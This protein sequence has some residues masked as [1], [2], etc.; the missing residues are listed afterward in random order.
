MGKKKASPGSTAKHVAVESLHTMK[1]G[2]TAIANVEGHAA[3][4]DSKEFVAARSALHEIIKELGDNFFGDGPVQAHHGGSI[5]VHDGKSWRM[6]VNL[7]GIEWS[8]QFAC[9]P[10]KVDKLRVNAK[11]LVDA[12]PQTIPNLTRIGYH[13]AERILGTPIVDGDTIG[14]FV[15]SLY[16]ACVPLPQPVHTGT[17]QAKNDRA[18]G[19]HS[20]PSPNTDLVFLCRTDFHPFVVDQK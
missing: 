1:V 12:F 6:F 10:E 9:D 8:G 13:D 19:R 3:R 14:A 5:W 20:Y 18:A 15:D 2:L 4:A 7:A 16:N 11:L 17:I